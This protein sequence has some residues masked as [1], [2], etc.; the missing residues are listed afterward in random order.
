MPTPSTSSAVPSTSS[1]GPSTSTPNEPDVS[2]NETKKSGD[3]PDKLTECENLMEFTDSE[4]KSSAEL[5]EAAA[6]VDPNISLECLGNSGEEEI[7]SYP[8]VCFV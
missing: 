8:K 2:Q 3:E 6:T 4:S 5:G 7:E 1:A